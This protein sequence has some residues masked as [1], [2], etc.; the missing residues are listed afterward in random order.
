MT[1]SNKY[2]RRA[3]N[4]AVAALLAA[5]CIAVVPKAEANSCASGRSCLGGYGTCT[6]QLFGASSCGCDVYMNGTVSH[7]SDESCAQ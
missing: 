5:T 6:G 2:A 4:C 7:E 3:L 1:L